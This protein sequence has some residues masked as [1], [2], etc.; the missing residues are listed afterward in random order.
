M[1]L[2]VMVDTSVFNQSATGTRVTTFL[3]TIC[4]T[5]SSATVPSSIDSW[6]PDAHKRDVTAVRPAAFL[7]PGKP[8]VEVDSGQLVAGIST[9]LLGLSACCRSAGRIGGDAAAPRDWAGE[10]VDL[11]G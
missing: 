3:A 6:P 7:R 10:L 5:P 11:V 1:E 2:T 8:A 9:C 4:A